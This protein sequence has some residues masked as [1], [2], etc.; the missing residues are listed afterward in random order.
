[1]LSVCCKVCMPYLSLNCRICFG[2]IN[3]WKYNSFCLPPMDDRRI[4]PV[5]I[6]LFIKGEDWYGVDVISLLFFH[7]SG[8]RMGYSFR[9]QPLT[10]I[11]S[12]M[13]YLHYNLCRTS[14]QPSC[15]WFPDPLP[16]DYGTLIEK[17]IAVCV[18]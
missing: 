9:F 4:L 5:D 3:R 18:F 15:S 13:S 10:S 1:M 16:S 2:T 7:N 12:S 17:F 6:F 14:Y 11:K 8:T